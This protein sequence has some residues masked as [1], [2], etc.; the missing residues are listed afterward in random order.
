MLASIH[1]RTRIHNTRRLLLVAAILGGAV[2][3]P[4]AAWAF[5]PNL[6]PS[7]AI[8]TNFMQ[9][10]HEPKSVKIQEEDTDG[11]GVADVIAYRHVNGFY[12]DVALTPGPDGPVPSTV[13]LRED[14]KDQRG[15][16]YG[17]DKNGDG[18]IDMLARGWFAENK[19]DQMLYDSDQDG[20]PD[21][22]YYD[23]DQNGIFDCMGVDIDAD[24]KLD[25]LY[26]LD[27]KTGDVLNETV[28]W[29]S[30]KEEQRREA[31]PLLYYSFE[32]TVKTLSGVEPTVVSSNW[33][34]G[35]GATRDTDALV[36]GEHIYQKA[37]SYEVSLEIKFKMPGSERVYKA[38]YGISLPV[39][40]PPPGPPP[41]S[42]E[43]VRS[44]V[45]P[46]FG[47]CGFITSSERP[48]EGPINE[49]W[50]AVK[51]PESAPMGNALRAGAVV[52]GDLELTAYWWRSEAE[53]NAFLDALQAAPPVELPGLQALATGTPFE[54]VSKV[55]ARQLEQQGVRT[56]VFRED[57]FVIVVS[58]NRTMTELQRWAR[59]LYDI[60]HPAT[61][62]PAEPESE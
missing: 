53:A 15:W 35:D 27:N 4:A 45:A 5:T 2:A 3:I 11:D 18:K 52:P 40:A 50:P 31:L 13:I 30:F 17:F 9:K 37:G 26:D 25:Y 16:V 32:P 62:V 43:R 19:W 46:F 33:D 7:T 51:L 8:W 54:L 60:M 22:F 42:L 44:A 59:V 10:I 21:R 29:V 38:W 58:T 56:A 12:I 41:L 23:L 20:R 36:A 39:E 1:A 55:R 61:G 28:G 24:G 49:L 47:A 57:A 6:L 14:L 48:K 34:F